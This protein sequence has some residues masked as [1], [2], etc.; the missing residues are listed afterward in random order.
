MNIIG[1]IGTSILFLFVVLSV[2]K[3]YI[4][5]NVKIEK[6]PSERIGYAIAASENFNGNTDDIQGILENYNKLNDFCNPESLTFCAK[7]EPFKYEIDPE[8]LKVLLDSAIP[9]I[10]DDSQPLRAGQFFE[11]FVGVS[12]LPLCFDWFIAKEEAASLSAALA[13]HF[14]RGKSWRQCRNK[15]MAAYPITKSYRRERFAEVMAGIRDYSAAELD[16]ELLDL[17]STHL[18]L[19]GE[20]HQGAQTFLEALRARVL[21]IKKN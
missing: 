15:V 21:E 6:H 13:E 2:E 12:P 9:L 17:Y 16:G 4:Q 19:V 7:P 18:A 8:L 14:C 3:R 20:T 11:I 5:T 1:L 10:G